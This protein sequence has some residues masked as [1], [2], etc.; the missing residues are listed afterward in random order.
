MNLSLKS[1]KIVN[2]TGTHSEAPVIVQVVGGLGNQMFQYA[3]GLAA[4][5]H[6]KCPL[7]VDIS[8]FE[9]QEKRTFL[10]YHWDIDVQVASDEALMP[11]ADRKLTFLTRIAHHIRADRILSRSNCVYQQRAMHYDPDVLQIPPPVLLKGY[12]QSEKFFSDVSDRL[13]SE[14]RPR[15]PFSAPSQNVFRQIEATDWPVAVHVRRGDY[16]HDVKTRDIHGSCADDYYKLAMRI[17]D[18]LSGERAHYFIFS[19]EPEGVSNT[20]WAGDRTTIVNGNADRPWEDLAL[21]AACRDNI[22]ANSS[23][24]WWGAWL[25]THPKKTVVAPRHWFQR[26]TMLEISTVDLIPDGWITI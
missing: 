4:A 23:F 12:F 21:M 7:K 14:F 18:G 17:I 15:A 25:N 20:F 3:A 8:W 16:V 26:Q 6:H 9:R 2:E 1:T 11:F 22:V 10:L 13:R 19:D 24:S 5:H